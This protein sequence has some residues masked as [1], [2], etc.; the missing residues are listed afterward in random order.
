MT[1]V[2]VKFIPS[3]TGESG[4]ARGFAASECIIETFCKNIE[5]LLITGV[6]AKNAFISLGCG[7]SENLFDSQ[8]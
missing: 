4:K 8:M 5:L 7:W 1:S 2:L 6:V 3:N